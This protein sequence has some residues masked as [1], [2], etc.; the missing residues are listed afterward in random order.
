MR[1]CLN[2]AG[3][4]VCDIS[5]DGKMV[6]IVLKGNETRITAN[7]DGTLSIKNLPVEEST[8]MV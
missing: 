6:V 7:P 5:D 2:S 3:K 8:S 1:A 4:R